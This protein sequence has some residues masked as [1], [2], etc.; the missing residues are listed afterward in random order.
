MVLPLQ[1]ISFVVFT[2]AGQ[3]LAWPLNWHK[4]RIAMRLAVVVSV[5]LLMV[6]C[7]QPQM[8][9][10]HSAAGDSSQGTQAGEKNQDTPPTDTFGQI[11]TAYSQQG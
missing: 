6:V 7:G 9:S 4:G 1:M 3:K 10:Q 5:G 11:D 8:Q 2:A